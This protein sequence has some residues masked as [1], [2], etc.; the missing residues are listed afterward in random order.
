MT[1]VC[2]WNKAGQFIGARQQRFNGALKLYVFFFGEANRSGRGL[3]RDLPK[4]KD[5][6]QLG[7][8]GFQPRR[9]KLYVFFGYRRLLLSVGVRKAGRFT[10]MGPFK[11][12]LGILCSGVML[13]AA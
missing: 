12:A 1:L 8:E 9:S 11:T 5:T 2:E 6:S 7:Y 10:I 4:V 13:V 3:M